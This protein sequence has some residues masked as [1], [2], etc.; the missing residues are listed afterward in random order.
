MVV[1][2]VLGAIGASSRRGR[3]TYRSRGQCPLRMGRG[4]PAVAW[5]STSSEMCTF[6]YTRVT[7]SRSSRRSTSRMHGGRLIDGQLELG[8]GNHGH[9]G[10]GY[11]GA[12]GS[13][14]GVRYRAG[15]LG[16]DLDFVPSTLKSSAPSVD[17]LERQ[18]IGILLSVGLAADHAARFEVPGDRAGLAERAATSRKRGPDFGDGAIA[19]V[20]GGFDQQRRAARAVPSYT[21]S[22]SEA[23]SP[24]PTPRWI[25]RWMVSMGM[26]A[27]RA[28]RPPCASGRCPSG[29]ARPRALRRELAAELGEELAALDSL[30]PLARLI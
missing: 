7:S 11:L 19:I 30:T 20:G 1:A 21:T 5:A 9:F 26:L 17:G 15:R 24:P 12:R 27:S 6:V 13:S 18:V 3:A 4:Q 8:L 22:S 29:S 14:A 25:A 2:S 23:P 10:A 16:Q 28:G